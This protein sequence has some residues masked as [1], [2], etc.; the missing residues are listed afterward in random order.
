MP[1]MN[2]RQAAEIINNMCTENKFNNI[3]IFGITGF[4]SEEDIKALERAGM[5]KVYIKPI[6]K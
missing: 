1:L 6:S 3:P 5:I 2:G 4:S